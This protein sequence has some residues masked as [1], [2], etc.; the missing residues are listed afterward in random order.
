MNLYFGSYLSII[1]TILV[2]GVIVYIGITTT[3][4]NMVQS[5]GKRIAILAIWGL[6][7]CIFA[8]TRDGY[9]L[10]VQAAMEPA[11]LPGV[12]TLSSIQS[13]LC[14]IGGAVIAFCSISSIFIRKQRYWKAMFY[15]LSATILFKTLVIEISRAVL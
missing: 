12:F 13:T 4:R 1:S 6:L 3:K 10:S 15:I 7:V 11:V 14:C 9:H 5:W 8:A 2:I